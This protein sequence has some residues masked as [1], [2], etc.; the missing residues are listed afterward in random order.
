MSNFWT[1]LGL[2]TLA[3]LLVLSARHSSMC[4][5]HSLDTFKTQAFYLLNFATVFSMLWF[6]KS[7]PGFITK[8]ESLQGRVINQLQSCSKCQIFDDRPTLSRHCNA[9]N[10]CVRGY[11]HHCFVLGNCVG[12]LNRRVFCMT[13]WMYVILMMA[14]GI[15]LV[16]ELADECRFKFIWWIALAMLISVNSLLLGYAAFHLWLLAT[17]KTTSSALSSRKR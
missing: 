14:F 16:H 2:H 4:S 9:C 1:V 12:Q 15:I 13:L 17:G 5:L 10:R 3:S 11:D 6:N 8:G 7:D